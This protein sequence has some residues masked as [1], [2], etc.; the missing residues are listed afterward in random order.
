MVF[1]SRHVAACKTAPPN[2]S[3][4]NPPNSD[5]PHFSP[6]TSSIIHHLTT[7]THPLVMSSLPVSLV[8]PRQTQAD[9]TDIDS[10]PR[11]NRSVARRGRTRPGFLA[12][13]SLRSIKY[14]R[15][16]SASDD[17]EDDED[18]QSS[19]SPASRSRLTAGA[20]RQKVIGETAELK[21]V[22]AQRLFDEAFGSAPMFPGGGCFLVKCLTEHAD[23]AD[24]KGLNIRAI[25]DRE[26]VYRLRFYEEH[27]DRSDA[28]KAE[29]VELDN[30]PDQ[31]RDYVTET[32]LDKQS[33]QAGWH[34]WTGSLDDADEWKSYD[35]DNFTD[36][37]GALECMECW[38]LK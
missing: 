35:V 31:F 13:T 30:L 37:V 21:R 1:D 36:G 7:Q 5:R 10:L 19:S 3:F 38:K 14:K 17:D 24:K 20:G 16:D 32:I 8:G 4:T 15:R 11:A 2:H 25:L 34:R 27:L 29:K 18:A 12:S 26:V 6:V 22:L 23:D 9:A 33:F 28:L